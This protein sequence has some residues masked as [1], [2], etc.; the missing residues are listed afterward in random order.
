MDLEAYRRDVMREFRRTRELA[1]KAMTQV[2]DED[3]FAA[4]D[5][6]TNP[7]AIVV[8]HVAGNLRSR[9]TDFLT[10]DGEKP[11]RSRD[12]EFVIGPEDGRGALMA[13]WDR[14]WAIL[15][16]TLEGLRDEDLD[17]TVQIRGEPHTV[18]QAIHRQLTHYAYH[19][20]QIVLLAR[21]FAGDSWK[22]LSVPR[23]GSA[24]FNQR[25]TSYL[26]RPPRR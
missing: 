21:H 9:W 10:T 8:K 2:S 14:G 7:I 18:V 11:D 26:D 5:P 13:R 23:G 6:W 24:T 20:G 25:P 1:D 19:A 4:P 12:S 17:A 15:F 22:T 16:A 3:F